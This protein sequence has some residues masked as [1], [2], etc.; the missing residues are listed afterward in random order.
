MAPVLGPRLTSKQM[1]G[2]KGLLKVLP[3]VCHV[4]APD[5]LHFL[6]NIPEG[7]F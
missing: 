4:I 7:V 3:A 2:V 6:W 5:A 1:Q